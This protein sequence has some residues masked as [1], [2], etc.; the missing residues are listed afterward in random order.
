MLAH[1][2]AKLGLR[3]S[4][5]TIRR[6]LHKLGFHPARPV[7]SVSSPDPD[8]ALK[9]AAL[10]K[11]QTQAMADQL[12]LLYQDEVDLALLP[13]VTRL[14]TRR[15]EQ[16]KVNT[17]RQ[18]QKCYGFGAV[19]YR[20]GQL[21]RYIGEHKDT[22]NF[23]KLLAQLGQD[24][25]AW[26]REHKIKA[27]LVI[28]NYS[29]HHSHKSKAALVAEA[30]WLEVFA[31]P[32]YSPQLNLI[33]RLWHQLRREVTDN[34]GFGSLDKLRVAVEQFFGRLDQQ[35]Q[36]ALTIIGNTGLLM[37]SYLAR[38]QDEPPTQAEMR[39]AAKAAGRVLAADH[40]DRTW[41]WLL[42]A[43]AELREAYARRNL[44]A[45]LW[46]AAWLLSEVEDFV[47]VSSTEVNLTR[48]PLSQL[49]PSTTSGNFSTNL[50][51]V[52]RE[53]ARRRGVLGLAMDQL[54]FELASNDDR[55]SLAGVAEALLDLVRDYLALLEGEV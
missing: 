48:G 41:D 26:C 55:K 49:W 33:E 7:L 23:I 31:L 24:Y 9:A 34:Y 11:L 25:A 21:S 22:D 52:E 14:W 19:N 45:I 13:T 6:W 44:A 30:D 20:T 5:E 32:T 3:C 38:P 16:V 12:I 29:V 46:Q 10:L 40:F 17:P 37:W 15:G 2:Q 42:S 53:Y 35:P 8:Y 43:A 50:A 28:D 36:Q 1:L 27:V 18:N 51:A 47:G 54:E 39:A 4:K